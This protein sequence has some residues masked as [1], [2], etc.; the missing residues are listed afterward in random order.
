MYKVKAFWDFPVLTPGVPERF[1]REAEFFRFTDPAEVVVREAIQN[2]LDARCKDQKQVT[3]RFT[4][5]RV[6]KE[7][8]KEYLEKLEPHL[9][10]IGCLPPEH[11]S[12]PNIR[13]LTIEDF[14]TTG[15]DGET[16]RERRMSEKSNFYDFWW[17]EGIS[18]K[19][20][21][22]AGRWG[23]GKIS[24]Y[25]VS[26]LR[27]IWGVTVRR[28]DKRELM[29]GKAMLK[30]HPLGDKLYDYYGYFKGGGSDEPVEE[31]EVI[32]NFKENFHVQRSRSE[33][34]FSLIIP[35]P[36]DEITFYHIVEF[37]IMHY[38]FAI[39]KGDLK[40][41]VIDANTRKSLIIDAGNL[42]DIARG[43]DW[44]DTS[45]RDRDVMGILH[46][47]NESMRTDPKIDL[48]VDR[49]FEITENSFGGKIDEI[50]TSFMQGHML[51]FRMH[52]TI[53]M[54]FGVFRNRPSTYFDVFLKRY[55][56]Q[57][58]PDE[59]Y[60]RSDILIPDV[61]SI[62]KRPVRAMLVA[63]DETISE[64][65]G[66]CETPAHVNWN[67]RTGEFREKYPGGSRILQFI[68][69][70]MGRIVS[71]L[72]QPPRESL[73][74]FL[75]DIF[76]VLEPMRREKE[77][78]TR[79]P[80]IPPIPKPKQPFNI[81]KTLG[82]FRIFLEKDV[83]PPIIAEVEV[84]YDTWRG[85]PFKRYVP[86]D[87]DLANK[88]IKKTFH[89]CTINQCSKNKIEFTALQDD[90]GLEVVGFDPK[91]DLVVRVQRK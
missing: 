30:P 82:G 11:S 47:V 49:S 14:G 17:R 34:G 37:I 38:F 64:F 67:E 3:V 43:L 24:F 57:E 76:F 89:G 54:R 62:G 25:N 51:H 74:D 63:E 9:D 84:A 61:N 44:K 13:F 65:L 90:F 39:L 4:I 16:R 40:V 31:P 52:L 75:I 77:S 33:F 5:G 1:P 27:T 22:E 21:Q 35:M 18:S 32:Q 29:L 36:V 12:H 68:R 88:S 10:A 81:D 19:S 83:Q 55:A 48:N 7:N 42:Q 66:D 80:V 87:F 6:P 78:I 60:I 8:I 2:S 69:K 86:F 50:R 73:R 20:G 59:F 91:R 23:V 70:S 46:F 58:K 26:M 41:E 15:L 56:E 45:W 72:D 85:N 28:D 79:P 71:L 53:D